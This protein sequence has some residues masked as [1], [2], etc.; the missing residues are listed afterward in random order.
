MKEIQHPYREKTDKRILTFAE[1]PYEEAKEEERE[2][3][4][5]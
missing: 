3:A 2:W 1:H 4:E 5:V